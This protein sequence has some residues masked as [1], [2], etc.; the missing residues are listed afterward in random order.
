MMDKK[1]ANRR[2]LFHCDMHK[3]IA[4]LKN[5]LNNAL[6]LT[7]NGDK[8]WYFMNKEDH[9][10]LVWITYQNNCIVKMFWLIKKKCFE[11]KHII[12]DQKQTKPRETDFTV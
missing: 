2:Q 6:S 9:Q 8:S 12:R 10:R 3:N 4:A 1:V 7:C 5:F 11:Y